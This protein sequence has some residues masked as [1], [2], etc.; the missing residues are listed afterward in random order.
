[1]ASISQQPWVDNRIPYGQE[2]QDGYIRLIRLL[3]SEDASEIISCILFEV[4]LTDAPRWEALSYMWGDASSKET[5]LINGI[6]TSIRK[7]LWDGLSHLV[8]KVRS[9]NCFCLL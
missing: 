3:P 8:T 7:N 1:M 6:K 4:S 9:H 2:L 5:V